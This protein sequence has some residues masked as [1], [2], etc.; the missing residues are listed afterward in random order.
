MKKKL[1]N[2]FVQQLKGSKRRFKAVIPVL[3]DAEGNLIDGYHRLASDP[4]WFGVI[5][6][7]VKTD[8]DR[9]LLKIACNFIRRNVPAKEKTDMLAELAKATGWKAKEISYQTG[10]PYSTVMKYLPDEFKDEGMQQLALRRR[11]E[12]K[13]PSKPKVDTRVYKPKETWEQRKAVMAPPV[14]KMDESVFLA[15]NQRG[16]Y[17]EAQKQVCIKYVVPDLWFELP[18]RALAVFL[19]GPVHEGREE[20][21]MANRELLAKRGVE[22][23]EISYKAPTKEETETI[24]EK[25]MAALHERGLKF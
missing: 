23:L 2:E 25:V 19:D 18:D 7:W 24:V 12:V 14:S 20:R 10:I 11:A 9:A 5:L 15:L 21:D 16:V 6:S 17:P 13:Q 4:D 1:N 8:Q 3:R 22:V